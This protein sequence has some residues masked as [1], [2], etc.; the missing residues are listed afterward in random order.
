MFFDDSGDLV[1]LLVVG[2]LA[3][4]WLVVVLRVTGN[5]TLA[6][7]HAFDFIV[8]VAFGSTLA[9]VL[10]SSTVSLSEGALALALLAVLQLVAAWFSARSHSL[11]HALTASPVLLLRDGEPQRDAMQQHRIAE[12]SLLQSARSS[13]VGGLEL[14]AAIVLETNGTMSVITRSQGGSGSALLDVAGAGVGGEDAQVPGGDRR[15]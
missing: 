6:Q 3:Y 10:L 1:R 9:T 2:P 12:E 5:R 7:L 4:L 14:V 13:G 8:T 11:R 15:T